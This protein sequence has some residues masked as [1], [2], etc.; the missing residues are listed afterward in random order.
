VAAER[1]VRLRD[2]ERGLRVV[3]FR[4]RDGLTLVQLAGALGL[5]R[6]QLALRL[7]A[8][9]R[10]AELAIVESRQHRA[11]G[12]GRALGEVDAD[13][14]RIELAHHLN[15]LVRL[16]GA[17]RAELIAHRARLDLGDLDRRRRHLESSATVRAAG[18]LLGAGAERQRD[19]EQQQRERQEGSGD[20]SRIAKK[21]YRGWSRSH[22]GGGYRTG[23][24]GGECSREKLRECGIESALVRRI[25]ALVGD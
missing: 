6:G 12:D 18:A 11:L 16:D 1:F 20:P 23:A 24:R 17:D 25:A 13:H 7:G 9:R 3:H 15:D 22:G 5:G 8:L 10:G 14:R 4:L 21:T 2:P 19:G